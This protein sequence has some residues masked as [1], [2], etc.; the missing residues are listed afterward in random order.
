MLTRIEKI[1]MFKEAIE[2]INDPMKLQSCLRMA[3]N[4]GILPELCGY[5]DAKT[6]GIYQFINCCNYAIEREVM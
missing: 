4:Y 1:K 3:A 6:D 2:N 5:L